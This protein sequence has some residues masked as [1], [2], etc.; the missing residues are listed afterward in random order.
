MALRETCPVCSVIYSVPE[1]SGL[2]KRTGAGL[3]GISHI[4]VSSAD[5]HVWHVCPRRPDLVA[6]QRSLRDELL[7]RA[8][9][10]VV[11]PSSVVQAAV[12]RSRTDDRYLV[13]GL[14][15]DVLTSGLMVTEAKPKGEV[16][17]SVAE[18]LLD[19]ARRLYTADG[20]SVFL[21]LTQSGSE[22]AHRILAAERMA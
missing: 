7:V 20:V 8:L 18:T 22:E 19:L 13:V 16:V 3:F 21:R 17:S 2:A 15:A 12:H 1:V 9:S 5:G 10:G 6:R 11:D 4:T 14:C